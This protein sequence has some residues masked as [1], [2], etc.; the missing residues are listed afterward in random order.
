[1]KYVGLSREGEVVVLTLRRGKVNAMNGAVVEEL[2]SR[3]DELVAEDSAKAIVLTGRGKFF[4]FGLDVP[5]L[6]PLS[7]DEFTRFVRMFTDLYT[8]IY[9]YPKPV[10]A[11]LNGHTVA[12][13]CML[14]LA[15][16]RRL[17]AEGK[18]KIALNEIT[19]GSS[20]FAG[21][22]EML[23]ACVGES[24]AGEILFSGAMFESDKAATLGLVD[25]IV[26]AGDLLELAVNEA[27]AM[28][29]RDSQAFASIKR[30]LHGPVMEAIR[31]RE[32]ESIREFVRIWYSETTRR[33]LRGIEIRKD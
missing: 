5:E 25:R 15:C 11:A 12:G 18:G 2:R 4:S 31:S 19:F 13:G 1:M 33:E 29:A 9:V 10:I 6:F 17:M 22:V 7:K 30:L 23:R 8:A 28:A 26:P 3:F 21:S 14:A 20:V 32:N 24:N 27:R 16:D